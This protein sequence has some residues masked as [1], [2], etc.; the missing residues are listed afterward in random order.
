MTVPLRYLPLEQRLLDRLQR[1]DYGR[2]RRTEFG[3][4]PPFDLSNGLRSVKRTFPLRI[5][6]Q[7][8]VLR[9]A[10]ANPDDKVP[11]KMLPIT[12]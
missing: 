11:K 1:V 7:R 5:Y 9:A 12:P 2:P 8:Y 3:H 6:R 4:E 10:K